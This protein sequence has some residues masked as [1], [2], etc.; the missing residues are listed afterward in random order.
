MRSQ[1]F[2]ELLLGLS[3]LS[4]RPS[5]RM[6]QL[7]SQWMDFG[8]ILYLRFFLKSIRK[9]KFVLKLTIITANLHENISTFV[10]ITC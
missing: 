6:E 1:N 5:V 3:C 7:G 9:F 10:T 2:K 8:E 4:V